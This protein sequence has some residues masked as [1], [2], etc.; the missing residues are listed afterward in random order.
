MDTIQ[1]Q[2]EWI[3][4]GKIGCVFAS[5]LVKQADQIGWKFI[6]AE[7][8]L[9]IPKD[10][11]LV[12]ILFPE[13][14]IESVKQWALS[15][16]FYLEDINDLYQGLRIRQGTSISWVQYFGPDSH[17]KTRRS[18]YPMLSFTV[19]LSPKSYWRVGFNGILHLAHASVKFLTDRKADT[20]WKQSLIK[21]KKEIGHP[22]TIREAAK[23]TYENN[24]T[25]RTQ[26][27]E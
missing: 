19:K 9:K 11:F 6:L 16:G 3:S 24:I 15:N 10:A 12:S 27:V 17:V 18:P 8:K 25:T 21:T 13:G 4:S 26:E 5:A 2:K 1:Q 7:D 22:L 23:T 14:N 20:L